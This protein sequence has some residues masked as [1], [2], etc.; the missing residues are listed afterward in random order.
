[1]NCYQVRN[2]LLMNLHCLF[3]MYGQYVF[4]HLLQSLLAITGVDLHFRHEFELTACRT[5]DLN[6]Y[7]PCERRGCCP[8]HQWHQ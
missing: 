2:A 1:M 5:W 7:H 6:P 4:R 3:L 8:L